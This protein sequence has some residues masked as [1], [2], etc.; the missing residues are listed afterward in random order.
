MGLFV[1]PVIGL[2][3]ESQT[4]CILRPLGCLLSM[5]QREGAKAGMVAVKMVPSGRVLSAACLVKGAGR[6]WRT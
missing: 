2:K 4:A 5:R 3:H 1:M 6:P